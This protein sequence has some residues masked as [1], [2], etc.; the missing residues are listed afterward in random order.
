LGD[1]VMTTPVV[2]A[3]RTMR[4]DLRVTVAVEPAFAAVLEGHPSVGEILPVRGALET[5]RA[6]RGRGFSLVYNQHGG[7][8]SAFYASLSGAP[9]RV[10]WDNCQYPFLYNVRV[11]GSASFYGLRKVHTIEHRMT[12]LYWTGLERG[13]VPPPRVFPQ[14][15]ALATV[16]GKLA[17]RGLSDGQPYAVLHPGAGTFT[18]Q[19]P[20]ANFAAIARWLREEHDI[21]PVVRLGPGERVMAD[22]ARRQ[23]FPHSIVFEPESLDLREV[24][25]LIAGAR[26]FVGND[27][28]PAHLA[29]ATGRPSVVIFGSTDSATWR[30]WRTEHRVVQNYFSCNPCKADRCYAFSE[31]L[32]ILSVTEDQVRESCRELLPALGAPA[33]SVPRTAGA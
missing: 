11:P 24:I 20:L 25:A 32:C 1:V 3:L 10:C 28:G 15:D 2:A 14:P 12:Q 33:R 17:K 27:S 8:T 7:P 26:L 5:L 30:P 31:P 6:I 9:L 16:A 4:P 13:P 21:F 22:V 18:K 19:W 23:F 29:T